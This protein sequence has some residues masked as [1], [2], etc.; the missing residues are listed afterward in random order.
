MAICASCGSENPERA[1]F[2]L[3][4]GERLTPVEAPER[5]RETVTILFSDVVGS[6]ALGERPLG[7]R[8]TLERLLRAEREG[9]TKPA[10]YSIER[11]PNRR[12]I[13]LLHGHAGV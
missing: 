3:E 6:T 13:A 2:C 4:C 12:S 11:Q 9:V 8:R 1:K 5:F 7:G 10:C